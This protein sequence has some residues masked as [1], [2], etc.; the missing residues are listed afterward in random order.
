MSDAWRDAW[1]VA[2]D[3]LELTLEQTERLLAGELPAEEAVTTWVPPLLQ[4]PLP[5][6]LLDRAQALLGRQRVLIERTGSSMTDARRQIG[7]VDRMAAA[8]GRPAARPVYV[9]LSA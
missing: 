9:D 4:A 2:L 6:D 5:D 7:L 8:G 1:S 3:E